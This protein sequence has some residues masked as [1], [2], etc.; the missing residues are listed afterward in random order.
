MNKTRKLATVAIVAV[1]TIIT[2]TTTIGTGIFVQEA[3]AAACLDVLGRPLACNTNSFI[4]NAFNWI[5]MLNPSQPYI[6]QELP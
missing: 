5:G 1:L 6:N 2:A 3:N 4:S